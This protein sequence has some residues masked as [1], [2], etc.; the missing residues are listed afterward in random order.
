MLNKLDASLSTAFMT[1]ARLSRSRCR[2]KNSNRKCKRCR[3][4]ECVIL[5]LK[6]DCAVPNP[7]SYWSQGASRRAMLRYANHLKDRRQRLKKIALDILPDMEIDRLGLRSECV[8]DTTATQL[9]QLLERRGVELPSALTIR[10]PN[11]W[12]GKE[13]WSVYDTIDDPSVADIFFRVGFRDTN[14]G[15][16]P[17]R[18]TSVSY[19]K[20]LSDHGYDHLFRQIQSDGPGKALYTAHR[21]FWSI[22]PQLLH[23]CGPS[24]DNPGLQ[25]WICGLF[26][27]VLR[28]DLTDGCR[29]G[30]SPEGCSPLK[31]MLKSLVVG[32]PM[33]LLISSD[34]VSWYLP[35]MLKQ[36]EAFEAGLGSRFNSLALRF[37]T[38]EALEIPHTCCRYPGPRLEKDSDCTSD[39]KELEDE[40]KHELAFLE[41]LIHEFEGQF[42]TILQD[43][44]RGIAGVGDFWRHT[45]KDRITR[46]RRDRVEGN[47]L[48]DDERQRAEEIGV[49]WDQPKTKSDKEDGTGNPHDKKTVDYWL[50]EL[51]RI[52]PDIR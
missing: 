44:R 12:V 47:D 52:E 42:A 9:V 34:F 6:A 24:E 40:Y 27:A 41:E 28:A 33:E 43:P 5:L 2:V 51:E 48:S 25:D 19:L 10:K 39:S 50:Y 15:T 11:E 49:V 14:V 31:M 22:G 35:E 23:P 7:T 37:L 45:W 36:L 38:L 29:C 20:W 26:S 30:C 16:R 3:C 32:M 18:L 8:L 17:H 13:A 1:A 4:S 46:V 21:T